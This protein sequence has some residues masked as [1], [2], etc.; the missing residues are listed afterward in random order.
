M[1]QTLSVVESMLKHGI[2]VV[3]AYIADAHDNQEGAAL[4]PEKTFGPGEAPYVKQLADFNA[5][6]GT[7]F[8]NL[9]KEGI[10]QSNTLFIFTPDEGDHAVTAAPTPANCDG[11]NTPCTYPA[12]GVGELDLDLNAAVA[13]AGDSTVFAIHSDDAAN[14]YIPG[15][16]DRTSATVR[17]L[18]KTMAGISEL[19]PE[20]STTESIL[21][22]DLG[23][24]LQGA[25]VDTVG[26]TMLH[27]NSVADPF[28]VPT[29][30]FFG[31]PD[32]FFQ[33]PVLI[34]LSSAPD[35]R[36]TT[37]T[38]RLKS[39]A[40]LS[41]WSVPACRISESR[42]RPTSSPITSMFARP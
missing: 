1:A 13:A 30:T 17:T 29:F 33:F 3:Y 39:A 6:F 21:G 19:N 31:N 4:S 40:P 38:S 18:E 15:Q 20:N 37:A 25:I 35:L 7:F 28:R 8:A 16:P 9:K 24:N 12:G 10:D 26:Q 14:T 11:V 5:A 36:G 34:L 32:F 23:P 41:V 22:T 27:M 42:S 2:H